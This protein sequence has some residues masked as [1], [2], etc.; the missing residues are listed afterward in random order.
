M[1]LAGTFHVRCLTLVSGAVG[2]R[3]VRRGSARTLCRHQLRRVT[4]ESPQ[5]TIVVRSPFRPARFVWWLVSAC[6]RRSQGR[7]VALSE[8]PRRGVLQASWPTVE[9]KWYFV[10]HLADRHDA[11]SW[12]SQQ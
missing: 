5:T 10:D 8:A 4:N 9:S 11:A 12:S 3:R 6:A 2:G 1:F 7:A